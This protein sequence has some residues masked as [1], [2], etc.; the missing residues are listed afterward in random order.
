[1]KRNLTATARGSNRCGVQLSATYGRTLKVSSLESGKVLRM[2][3]EA[4]G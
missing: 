3:E 2:L 4:Y 1:M